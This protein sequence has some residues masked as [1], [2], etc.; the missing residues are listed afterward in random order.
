MGISIAITAIVTAITTVVLSS[1]I[2]YYC[3]L[4]SKR[5]YSPSVTGPPNSGVSQFEMKDNMAYGHVTIDSGSKST[6][7]VIYDNIVI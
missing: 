3:C 2:T 4:K 1:F 7:R 5:S 6:E